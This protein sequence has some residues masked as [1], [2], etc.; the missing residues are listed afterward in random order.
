MGKS[1]EKNVVLSFFCIRKKRTAGDGT[2]GNN[3][4]ESEVQFK[5][6]IVHVSW[7]VV[8]VVVVKNATHNHLN[9]FLT[10]TEKSL[11][12]MFIGVPLSLT[13]L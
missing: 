3:K 8:V 4:K 1:Y 5:S 2:K 10:P 7:V 13:V 6:N 9:T 12:F 11:F